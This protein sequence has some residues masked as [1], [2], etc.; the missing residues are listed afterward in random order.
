MA[1]A[2]EQQVERMTF[3]QEKRLKRLED[4]MADQLAAQD[5]AKDDAKAAKAKERAD[6]KQAEAD[7]V[8]AE[9]AAEKQQAKDDKAVAKAETAAPPDPAPT[10]APFSMA[11]P[12]ASVEDNPKP[13]SDKPKR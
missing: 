9:A 8:K 1:T 7:E 12:F 3:D 6:A 10:H 5:K 13:A 2:T 11:N 4:L